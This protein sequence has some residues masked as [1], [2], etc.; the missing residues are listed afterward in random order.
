MHSPRSYFDEKAKRLLYT[1][2]IMKW[3]K[4]LCALFVFVLLTGLVSAC[5]KSVQVKK[6]AIQVK[7]K[8]VKKKPNLS[9]TNVRFD[10]AV[11]GAGFPVT[12]WVDVRRTKGAKGSS[13]LTLKIDGKTETAKNVWLQDGKV[14]TVFF[15]VTRDEGKY[16]VDINGSRAM[17]TVNKTTP[18][19]TQKNAEAFAT[20]YWRLMNVMNDPDYENVYNLLSAKDKKLVVKGTFIH[21]THQF[22]ESMGMSTIGNVEV[23]GVNGVADVAHLLV[24]PSNG[25]QW[26]TVSET[27]KI[28]SVDGR[29]H[30]KLDQADLFLYGA[31]ADDIGIKKASMR[32][33]FSIRS[34]SIIVKSASL[35]DAKKDPSGRDLA[36]VVLE[37][38]NTGEQELNFKPED[39]VAIANSEQLVEVPLADF[40]MTESIEIGPGSSVTVKVAFGISPTVTGNLPPTF[41]G[42]SLLV[43][44]GDNHYLIPLGL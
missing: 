5:K 16:E 15:E 29:W 27:F 1:Q 18:Q 7:K 40:G 9:A 3:K 31:K 6:K 24:D 41:S 32:D 28:V 10:P 42:Y 20:E 21:R 13:K 38:R 2:T 8:E 36:T 34:L 12:V 44:N 25:E 33:S 17:L 4:L 11:G 26:K 43:G 39:Y 35:D 37:V 14:A 30:P 19:P 23:D 22:N